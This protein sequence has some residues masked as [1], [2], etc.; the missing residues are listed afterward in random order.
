[1]KAW[2]MMAVL[3]AGCVSTPEFDPASL[4]KGPRVLAM[5]AEPPSVP[6][7]ESAKLSLMHTRFGDLRDYDV[8]WTACGA[9]MSDIRGSQYRDEALDQ[10]CGSAA[11]PLG[12]GKAAV[13][14]GEQTAALFENLDTV[15]TIIGNRLPEK[16]IERIERQVG[17]PLLVEVAIA[18]DEEVFRA[19]KRVLVTRGARH[20]NPPPPRFAMGD[21]LV[22]AASTTGELE[23]PFL[24]MAEGDEPVRVETGASIVL[25]PRMGSVADPRDEDDEA[26]DGGDGDERWLEDYQVLNARGELEMRTERAFYSWFVTGGE[27]EEDVTKSPLRDNE[28][29]TPGESGCHEMWLVVRDGHGGTSACRVPVIVGSME[30]GCP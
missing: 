14:P 4:V 5:V 11:L 1:M 13:L 6:P 7:G 20:H 24:C 19:V 23:D 10:G 3:L 21:Q 26:T 18:S 12:D 22:R 17:L 29:R 28:W 2:T 8:R 9:F 16:T 25:S 30:E 15:A 27:L